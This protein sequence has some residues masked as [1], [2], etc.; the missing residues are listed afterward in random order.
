MCLL[1]LFTKDL[2]PY[3]GILDSPLSPS[4]LF[5]YIYIYIIQYTKQLVHFIHQFLL[6]FYLAIIVRIPHWLSVW[7]KVSL[8]GLGHPSTLKLAFEMSQAQGPFSN[9]VSEPD[10]FPNVGLPSVRPML[11]H[12]LDV[13]PWVHEGL[14][15]WAKDLF[16]WSWAS[17]NS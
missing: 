10:P 15:V 14:G 1:G 2:Q 13:Q 17:L 4:P 12:T 7:A 3:L 8:Y 9:M 16:I 11:F 6:N 5:K